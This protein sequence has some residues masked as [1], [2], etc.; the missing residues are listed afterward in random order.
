MNPED[1]KTLQSL[2]NLPALEKKIIQELYEIAAQVVYD[3]VVDDEEITFLKKWLERNAS[4]SDTWPLSRLYS[5]LQQV[6]E[7]GRIDDDERLQLLLFLSGISVFAE[8]DE[9]VETI[10]ASNPKI[11]FE[12]NSFFIIGQLELVAPAKVEAQV[13]QRKGTMAA[14]AVDGLGYAVVGNLGTEDWETSDHA[15]VIKEALARREGGTQIITEVDFIRATIK[16]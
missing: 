5:L 10:F 2:C 6:L 13:A 9:E 16:A 4:F 3:G 14:G 1:K 8:E 11:S 7:D 15:E 12:G